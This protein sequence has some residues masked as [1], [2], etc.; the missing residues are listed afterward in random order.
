[1]KNI[2]IKVVH[3]PNRKVVIKRGI[4]AEHY[5]DYCE[6]V[7]CDIW[8]QLLSMDFRRGEPV[9]L[10]LPEKMVIPGTS[11]YVQGI[12]TGE[13]FT[14]S[15]P[16]GFDVITLPASDY[17][18]F[19]GQPFAEEN[20]EQA[21]GEVWD[22]MNVYDPSILGYSWDEESPRIQLEPQCERGYMELKAVRKLK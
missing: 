7:G 15:V 19:R 11:V 1:M 9:C 3:K 6:E 18:Q 8:E 16:D 13:D 12:E 22:M 21:I 14:G 4:K 20:F 5:F 2:E 10:W 17:L